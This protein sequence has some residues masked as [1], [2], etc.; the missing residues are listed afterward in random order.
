MQYCS[1]W[2]V[3]SCFPV[4]QVWTQ[5]SPPQTVQ[6]QWRIWTLGGCTCT[7]QW[8][9]GNGSRCPWPCPPSSWNDKTK[10][11]STLWGFVDE[12]FLMPRRLP[13]KKKKSASNSWSALTHSC[14]CR[15]LPGWHIHRL[16]AQ[17]P[18]W[19]L[20]TSCDKLL[21][22]KPGF[23]LWEL[24]QLTQETCT[25]RACNGS[26]VSKPCWFPACVFNTI[27]QYWLLWL[28]SEAR[29]LLKSCNFLSNR[30]HFLLS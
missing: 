20:T 7:L 16:Q 3:L 29:V 27:C 10:L 22:Q 25:E 1:Y 8:D 28:L 21:H 30:E 15:R 2:Q 13:K 4:F 24:K 9:T 14:R 26:K 12:E 18:G 17:N 11:S 19:F 6:E 23:L 5:W